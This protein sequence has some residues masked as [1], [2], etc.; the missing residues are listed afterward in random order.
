MSQS[1]S[2][3]L[4]AKVIQSDEA[5]SSWV[6]THLKRVER[7]LNQA[8][9][10]S[11]VN[12]ERLHSAMAYA[13]N[14]G[15]K[16]I[17]P[18]LVYAAYE[19]KDPVTHAVS[20]IDVDQTAAALEMLHTYSLVHDD[21]PA[22]D[23]DDLRRGKPTTHKAYDEATA[24]LVGDALQTQAFAVLAH[25]EAPAQ[26]RID[27]VRELASASGS[28]GMA[29]GQAIDLQSVGKALDR[30]ALEQMHRMKTGALLAASVRMGAILAGLNA[31]QLSSLDQYAKALGLG[32]QVVDDIL[33]V[34]QDSQVLG[35]TAGK[36]AQADKPTF[37]SLM[38]LE[39]AQRFANE[40]NDQALRA[41]EG[42]GDQANSLRQIA[43][44]VTSRK[45]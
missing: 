42:W 28:M 9:P 7:A 1:T 15:G 36:D 37:V 18:L 4:Q 29:G 16:R 20:T 10:R 19:L 8:L 45:H 12:P 6:A 31:Q 11:T 13:V 33:D 21:L 39:N 17:R 27:L 2:Q 26:M 24:L 40:L 35:K 43:H 38:G 3:P 5:W 32:F 25:L 14:A 22:M 34:T 30:A 41:L 23:N 44:W